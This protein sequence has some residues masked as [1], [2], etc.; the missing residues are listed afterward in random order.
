MST[1]DEKK[2][3]K[4]TAIILFAIALSFYIGFIMIGVLRS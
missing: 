4:R 2:G 1:A 3:V